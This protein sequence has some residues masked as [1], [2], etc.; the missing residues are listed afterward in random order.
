MAAA[1][2][3]THLMLARDRPAAPA[4]VEQV[5]HDQAN[6]LVGKN[7]EVARVLEHAD[8]L[9]PLA[10][11]T[12]D[13]IMARSLAIAPEQRTHLVRGRLEGVWQD[14][15]RYAPSRLDGL[16][17]MAI[18][19]AERFSDPPLALRVVAFR[20]GPRGRDLEFIAHARNAPMDAHNAPMDLGEDNHAPF[21]ALPSPGELRN[22]IERLLE[23]AIRE[24]LPY[25]TVAEDYRW[26]ENDRRQRRAKEERDLSIEVGF[27]PEIY[28]LR[29]DQ[30]I[31]DLT[32]R[33]SPAV[34]QEPAGTVSVAAPGRSDLQGNTPI[35]P[36]P[37]PS[38][39]L[40]AR[41]AGVEGGQ[42]QHD[43][44]RAW[45]SLANAQPRILD[46]RTP[47]EVNR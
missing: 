32:E 22:T 15:A 6:F 11:A 34:R 29:R 26:Y 23:G 2:Q 42:A 19:F 37:A 28:D 14:L 12:A 3:S 41:A 25:Y 16:F 40:P 21:I 17:R 1:E 9:V 5:L 24:E 38:A 36:H 43:R 33:R 46:V 44:P 20:S 8:A 30:A 18:H 4:A 47:K 45:S 39:S 10:N 31:L 35:Q 13:A 27:G 7:A